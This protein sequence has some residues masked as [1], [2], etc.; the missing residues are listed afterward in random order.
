MPQASCTRQVIRGTT[1]YS[2]GDDMRRIMRTRRENRAK[3][4][5]TGE[6]RR[7]DD[8]AQAKTGTRERESEVTDER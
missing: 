6:V 8:G 4:T 5:S 7:W 2:I 1:N 3:A